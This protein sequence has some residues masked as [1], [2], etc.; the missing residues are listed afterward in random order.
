MRKVETQPNILVAVCSILLVVNFI[1]AYLLLRPL[2][3]TSVWNS[4]IKGYPQFNIQT[5]NALRISGSVCDILKILA[6]RAQD[7]GDTI[8]STFSSSLISRTANSFITRGRKK[9]SVNASYTNI[10]YYR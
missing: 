10:N 7:M 5:E 4:L 8:Q 2:G 9:Y 6:E 1:S 3:T